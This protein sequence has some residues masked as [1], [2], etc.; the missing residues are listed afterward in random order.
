MQVNG[1][2]FDIKEIKTLDEFLKENNYNINRIVVELNGEII[3]KEN[4]DKIK[5][6]NEDVIE[7]LNFVGGG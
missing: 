3:S 1:K 6:K 2:N 5:I 7:V 4:Y